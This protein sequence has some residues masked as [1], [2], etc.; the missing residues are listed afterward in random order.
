MWRAA[1][2]CI[3][4]SSF[5]TISYLGF[6]DLRIITRPGAPPRPRVD[7]LP[8]KNDRTAWFALNLKL[9]DEGARRL[10]AL[11]GQPTSAPQYA[12]SYRPTQSHF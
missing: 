5:V 4:S 11:G 12:P 8:D 1:T 6:G 9:S 10:H 3:A 7:S 2:A